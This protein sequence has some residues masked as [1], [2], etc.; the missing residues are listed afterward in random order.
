MYLT[1]KKKGQLKIK[2]YQAKSNITETLLWVNLNKRQN[3]FIE[4]F[5]A[6]QMMGL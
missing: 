4:F 5:A 1:V 3:C 6:L 2:L